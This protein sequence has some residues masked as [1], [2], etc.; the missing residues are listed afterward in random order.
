MKH[1]LHKML[2]VKE[3]LVDLTLFKY[4]KSGNHFIIKKKNEKKNEKK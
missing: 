3:T 4:E 2:Q 1:L